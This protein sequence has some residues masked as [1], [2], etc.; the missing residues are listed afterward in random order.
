[1]NPKVFIHIFW[2][3][4]VGLLLVLGD[5]SAWAQQESDPFLLPGTSDTENSKLKPLRLRTLQALEFGRLSADALVGGSITI[6]PAT[7]RK[8]TFRAQ[9]LGGT[10]GR[11]EFEITGEPNTRFLVTLPKKVAVQTA[12]N[13]QIT[14]T[15]F[16]VHPDKIGILSP[17][18]KAVI[19]VGATLNLGPGKEG[20]IKGHR[21]VDIYVDYLP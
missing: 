15:H 20:S 10:H 1:M 12:S 16:T 8:S 21:A 2:L 5:G 14:L 4:L 6:N 19:Q 9:N 3:P 7:G 17:N 13:K 18:G 11:A